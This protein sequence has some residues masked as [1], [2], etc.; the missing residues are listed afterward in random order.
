MER[1]EGLKVVKVPSS[2]D[3]EEINFYRAVQKNFQ[4]SSA[5]D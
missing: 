2:E 3:L 4:H 5:R 1:L